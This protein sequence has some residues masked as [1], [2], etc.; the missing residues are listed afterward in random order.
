MPP[1]VPFDGE[2][3]L[4]AVRN[5]SGRAAVERIFDM[6]SN[7]RGDMRIKFVNPAE[8][9]EDDLDAPRTI[10]P[11]LESLQP[12]LTLWWDCD[13]NPALSQALAAQSVPQVCVNM[14][15]TRLEPLF[16]RFRNRGMRTAMGK[17][18][19]IYCATERAMGIAERLRLQPKQLVMSGEIAPTQRSTS[20]DDTRFSQLSKAVSGRPMWFLAGVTADEL[21]LLAR[22]HRQILRRG[23][24]FLM[25]VLPHSSFLHKEA[26]K[27]LVDDGWQV[28]TTLGQ[29]S[30]TERTEVILVN[31]PEGLPL[32]YRL[33]PITFVGGTLSATG[34]TI[35]PLDPALLGSA[36]VHGPFYGRHNAGFS[37][38]FAANCS[39]QV[40][41]S[42]DVVETLQTLLAPDQ[43]A[44]LAHLAWDMLTQS[45][46]TTDDLVQDL[47]NFLDQRDAS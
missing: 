39:R 34:A 42:S 8:A 28:E 13:L 22:A 9:S 31:E 1:P 44:S 40:A 12:D 6:L 5:P 32:W 7:E 24:R 18:D 27:Q 23:M 26:E 33:S 4:A 37:M 25:A 2:T 16:S 36:L 3:I 19:R 45:A 30:F 41:T 11:F 10:N 14:R 46:Q 35:D 43:S 21:T 47:H 29:T 38:L 20:V 15:G 17:I